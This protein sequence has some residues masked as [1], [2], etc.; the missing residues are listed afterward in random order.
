MAKIVIDSN[1]VI[2][3]LDD[4]NSNHVEA[5]RSMSNPQ[6]EVGVSALTMTECLIHAFRDSYEFALKVVIEIERFVSFILE[7]NREIAILAAHLSAKF[8]LNLADSIILA[9]EQHHEL[10]LWTFDKRLA[11]KSARAKYLLNRVL[12]ELPS[13]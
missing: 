7:L 6:I 5:F 1:V 13:E 8:Q 11:S 2:A 9:T 4:A 10:E 3:Y 12:G